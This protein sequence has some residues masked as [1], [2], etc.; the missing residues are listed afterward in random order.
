MVGGPAPVR[1]VSQWDRSL[2]L[3]TAI[4]REQPTR[5]HHRM[6]EH[7]QQFYRAVLLDKVVGHQQKVGDAFQ[8]R[9]GRRRV[10]RRWR[11]EASERAVG[12]HGLGA[13]RADPRQ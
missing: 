13:A 7:R 10:M 1:R 12:G 4:S 8:R 3:G 6:S 9:A 5:G 2:G 11:D